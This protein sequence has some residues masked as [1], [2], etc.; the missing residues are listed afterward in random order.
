[1]SSLQEE[2]DTDSY[3][4]GFVQERRNSNVLAKDL[5]LSFA[6]LSR[7]ELS[8]ILIAYQYDR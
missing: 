3:I 2:N 6:N 1:M 5:H 7:H 8:V 4:D